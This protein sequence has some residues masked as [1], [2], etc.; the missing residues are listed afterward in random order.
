M[1]HEGAKVAQISGVHAFILRWMHLFSGLRWMHLSNTFYHL[2]KKL[3]RTLS[4]V[5]ITNLPKLSINQDTKS[6]QLSLL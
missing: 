1:L 2:N 5:H 4:S 3:H 6:I